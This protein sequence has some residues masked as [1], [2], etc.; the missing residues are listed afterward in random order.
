MEHLCR[1]L[2]GEWCRRLL[3][4]Q[5][6]GSKSPRLDGAILCPACGKIH[7]RCVEAMYPFLRMA[8]EEEYQGRPGWKKRRDEWVEGAKALFSWAEHT[9]SLED[10]SLLNDIDSRW[11]GITV[12]YAIQL[13]DCLRFCSSLLDGET[14]MAW[15]NRL[16]KAA[17]FLYNTPILMENNINYPLSNALALYQCGELLRNESYKKKAKELAK[18]A[19]SVLTENGLLFGEGVPRFQRSR[20]GCQPVDIGYNMEE[21]LPSLILYAWESGDEK[22]WDLAQKSL[23]AHL[24]FILADGGINNSF[25]TRNY[26]WSYWGSRTCDGFSLGYLLAAKKLKEWDRDKQA[27]IEQTVWKNL[28]LLQECTQDGLLSGGPHYK[29]AGQPS[30][31]H[32]TFTHAKVLAGILDRNLAGNTAHLLT[33]E[34]EENLSPGARWYPEIASWIISAPPV[35]A[36]ITCYD[37]E[38]MSGGHVGGGTL[39]LLHHRTAGPLFCAGMGEYTLKEPNNMQVPFR[40]RHRCLALR[41]EAE[42]DGR[43]YSSIYEDQAR[44]ENLSKDTSQELSFQIHGQLKDISHNPP[45][46]IKLPYRL[47]YKFLNNQVEMNMTFPRGKV[48]CPVISQKEE[49]LVSYKA[50]GYSTIKI[51]KNGYPV[52]L[53][54]QGKMELPYKEERIFNLV[55]GFQAVQVEISPLYRENQVNLILQY[56]DIE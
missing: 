29:S 17:E 51:M 22:T 2:L 24:D 43:I 56:P 50:A 46:D 53:K 32:H 33:D 27:K 3:D 49:K 31:V 7:G 15:T 8:K 28:E 34:K 30:C 19:G 21:T 47:E 14:Q 13:S 23:F 1:N 20:Q 9:V 42:V 6:R 18:L 48:I 52:Y 35:S 5:I 26:K 10:G 4:L 41:I 12:F 44:A 11:T 39:S 36:T 55:P 54:T 25:G 40:V 16:E 37:W 45:D 38:Y